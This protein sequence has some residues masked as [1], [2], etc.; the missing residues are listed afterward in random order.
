MLKV[1]DIVIK[2]DETA[3]VIDI[4]SD[5]DAPDDIKDKIKDEVGSYLI[6]QTLLSIAE[7]KSPISGEA[8]QANLS[9][10]YKRKKI[11]EGG[12][13]IANLELTG[14]MLSSLDYEITD[15]GIKLG[16]FGKE[17]LKADGHNNLSGSSDL[18]Q[19]RFLPDEGQDYKRSIEA[20]V[21]S[22][23]ADI[24]AEVATQSPDEIK[25]DLEDVS[26]KAELFDALESML[27]IGSRA[28]IVEAVLANEELRSILS[29][30]DLLDLLNA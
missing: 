29:D 4:V 21:E 5:I 27:N 20:G 30:L 28:R 17:A 6:E 8:W 16:I 9:P 18:P 19:R 2:D 25:Q 11:K 14:D 1:T 13:G 10:E 23:I 3:S 12:K 15:D 26:T 22:I 7:T 24:M